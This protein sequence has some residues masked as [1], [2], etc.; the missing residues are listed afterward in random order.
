MATESTDSTITNKHLRRAHQ[1]LKKGLQGFSDIE[2]LRGIC[3]SK[4]DLGSVFT[5]QGKLK[6]GEKLLKEGLELAKDIKF[7]EEIRDAYS[8]L[9]KNLA[10]SGEFEQAYDHLSKFI[11]QKD[12]LFNEERDKTLQTLE[13]KYQSKQK[14]EELQ[15]L[16]LENELEKRRNRTQLI[17]FAVLLLLVITVGII[18]W[19]QN[20]IKQQNKSITLEKERVI[21]F[22]RVNQ[23]KDQFLANTSHELRTPLQGI[24]GLSESLLELEEVEDKRENLSMIISSG[25]RLNSLVDDILDFS[26]LKNQDIILSKKAINLWVLTDIVLRNIVPLLKGKNIK[27]IN[28]V[29]PKLSAA[30]ADENRVQQILYNLIGNGIKFTEYGS[31]TVEAMPVQDMIQVCVKDT[32]IG[33]ERKKLQ[34][35][36][37]AFEQADGSISRKYSGTGLGLSISKKLV[38]LHGGDMWVES[39]EGQ[40]SIF[41]FTLPL[42]T[43]T[44]A[45]PGII[46]DSVPIKSIA[47]IQPLRASKAREEAPISPSYEEQLNILVVDDEAINQQVIKNHLQEDRFKLVQAMNGTEALQLLEGN[48]RFDLVLLDVMMPRMSGY[49]VCQRIREQY[50]PSELPVIMVTAKNQVSDLIQ[51]LDLGANDYLAKPFTRDEFLAR[52]KTHL[53]LHRINKVTNRFVPAEFIR[54]LGKDNLTELKLGDQVERQVT[55]LFTDIR[56]YTSLAEQMSPEENFRFVNAYAGRMG[57]IINLHNG[58]VNQY[59][60]DG[61]MAIF[62]QSPDDALKACIDMQREIDDYNHLRSQQGRRNIR[63]GMG[64][65]TGSLIMGIIGDEQRTDAAT[66]SDTVNTAARMEALTKQLGA[67]I[68]L[69]EQ[70]FQKLSD[71]QIY[72]MRYLGRVR[73]KGREAP[74]GVYEC[75]DSDQYAIQ[76]LKRNWMDTFDQAITLYAEQ[77]FAKA[78]VCFEEILDANPDDQIVANLLVVSK[79]YLTHGVPDRWVG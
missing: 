65:H 49:E 56:K 58:F 11:V 39:E 5:M 47:A 54:T 35:I 64:M 34:V 32:G 62:Q 37:E 73:V 36:F 66:I 26:K 8:A 60:G 31:I 48:L 71:P 20:R 29:D 33:I 27:L 30:F 67:P 70:S 22:Q 3:F 45:D 76:S 16:T 53:N 52:I 40:G 1:A 79:K 61:I 43:E 55:V 51:G 69:S 74:L 50:L 59:L 68:L 46:S 41:Y 19:A 6:E 57:P 42:G 63:V 75:F 72:Q 15:K 44:I 7:R 24:I 28:A 78:I 25:K 13:T 2:D 18:I 38:E 21:Y 10:K 9:A 77:S 14:A 4:V 12:S 23:L 17:L